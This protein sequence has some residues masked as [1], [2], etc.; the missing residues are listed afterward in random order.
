MCA[1]WCYKPFAYT[2]Q[3]SYGAYV[4]SSHTT[5]NTLVLNL[6]KFKNQVVIL[7]IWKY[8]QLLIPSTKTLQKSTN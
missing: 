8:W 4:A 3:E 7:M 6:S 2:F 5:L 1:P